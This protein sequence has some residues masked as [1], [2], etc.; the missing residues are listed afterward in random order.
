MSWGNKLLLVFIAFG[1]M[2]SFMVYRC[3][4]V[5]VNLVSK[6]YY[7]DEIAYQ[8]V[9]DSREKTNALEGKVNFSQD[10]T[11]IA[12]SLPAEMKHKPLNGN[13]LLYCPANMR[14]DRQF[15]LV[16]DSAASQLLSKQS[17]VPGNY[18]V[19]ISWQSGNTSYYS[20]EPLTIH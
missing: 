14:N 7:R 17:L 9:I 2:M 12:I 15:N 16:T 20:E 10:A 1:S 5:P 3:L 4:Q 11:S 6:E 19:K 18:V 13:I 8:Q